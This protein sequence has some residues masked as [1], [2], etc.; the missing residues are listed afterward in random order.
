M[1]KY[2][3]LVDLVKSFPASISLKILAS[4]QKRTRPIKF[5]HLAEK[6]EK[7]SLS[8][9]SNWAVTGRAAAFFE[10]VDFAGFFA[11]VTF[12]GFFAVMRADGRRTMT[13][14]DPSSRDRMYLTR[15]GGRIS[16]PLST[17]STTNLRGVTCKFTRNSV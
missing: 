2:V 3:N 7:G 9:L 8:N 6:S 11:V 15:S 12:A 5:N 16:F 4:I 10:V 14:R 17:T 1:E 13:Q